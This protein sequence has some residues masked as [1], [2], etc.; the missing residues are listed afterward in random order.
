MPM[1]PRLFDDRIN[2]GK[3][4]PTTVADPTLLDFNAWGDSSGVG[5]SLS[6]ITA[7]TLLTGRI[8]QPE[9]RARK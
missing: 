9:D 6:A 7:A 2:R 3:G 5:G 4:A 1:S 8:S